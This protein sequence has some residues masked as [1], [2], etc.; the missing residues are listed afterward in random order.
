[1]EVMEHLLGMKDGWKLWHEE[2]HTAAARVMGAQSLIRLF[3]HQA[4]VDFISKHIHLMYFYSH[5]STC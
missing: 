4:V 5:F 2:K 1:M 3:K